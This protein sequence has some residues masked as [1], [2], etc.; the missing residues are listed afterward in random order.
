LDISVFFKPLDIDEISEGIEY[1]PSQL[2]TSIKKNII[3]A[4]FPSVEECRI[5]IIGV[6][7]GR[8]SIV[9]HGC[10]DG[11]DVIRRHLYKLWGLG[12]LFQIVDLGNIEP[13]HRVEDTYFALSSTIEYLVK[14]NILPVI[15]GGGQDLTFANYK[16]YQNLEQL[17]NLVSIDA[18]FNLGF[19]DDELDAKT[20]LSKIILYQP[21]Y[22]FNYSNI[23]YQTY[24]VE[25]A[26]IELMQKLFFDSYRLGLVRANLEETEPIV[27]N[28]DIVSFDISAVRNSDAPGNANAGPNG[29]TGEE[30]CQIARY[31]GLSDKVTSVGFY[32]YSPVFDDREVTAHLIAQALWCFI[33]GVSQRKNDLP[34][35][36]HPDFLKYRVFVNESKHEIVFYKS[37]KSDR[38]W[39]EVPYPNNKSK[40]ERHHLVPCSYTDYQIACNEGMPD[41]WWQTYQKLI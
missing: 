30:F 24:F 4:D 3:N 11:P 29:F 16:G 36:S 6:K 10:S 40:Y 31:A 35:S 37:N 7:E 33:E 1:Q 19:I 41:R 2:G 8:G 32:E 20:Y 23:G 9:N 17:V 39:M 18:D 25:P 38:W 14:V 5:A 22:L 13:G 26:A 28:A 12:N 34:V 27:R 21:N 15:L